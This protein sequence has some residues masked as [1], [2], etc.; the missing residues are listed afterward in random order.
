M[1]E[2]MITMHIPEELLLEAKGKGWHYKEIFLAGIEAKKGLP[3][4]SNRLK[5]ANYTY[6][7]LQKKLTELSIRNIELEDQL[8]EKQKRTDLPPNPPPP[9]KTEEQPGK[10]KGLSI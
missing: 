9:P 2:K 7:K 3:A 6:E 8:K 4:I 1:P 10:D 5:E